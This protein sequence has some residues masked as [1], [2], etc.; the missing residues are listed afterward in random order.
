MYIRYFF[1]LY[2]VLFGCQPKPEPRQAPERFRPAFNKIILEGKGDEKPIV[3]DTTKNVFETVNG[4]RGLY[5]KRN[6]S[7]KF[8]QSKDYEKPSLNP[9]F[10]VDNDVD[11]DTDDIDEDTAKPVMVEPEEVVEDVTE[12]EKQ[13]VEET[14]DKPTEK[15]VEPSIVETQKAVTQTDLMPES[16]PVTEIVKV[17]NAKEKLNN[18]QFIDGANPKPALASSTE[19][20][21]SKGASSSYKI[22]TQSQY[23]VQVGSFGKKKNADKVFNGI[24]KT[25][26]D[27]KVKIKDVKV[28]NRQYYRVYVGGYE[29]KNDASDALSKIVK[30]GYYDAY[31]VQK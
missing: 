20:V 28:S 23:Y 13:V 15:P 30:S 4:T 27:G 2:L 9:S 6:S 3:E 17:S 21:L 11:D 18:I 16:D 5:L 31:V 12:D 7:V 24:E 19:K 8:S 29:T 26:G 14:V 10:G 25:L 22:S 1:F